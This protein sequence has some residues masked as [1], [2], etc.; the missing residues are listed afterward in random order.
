MEDLLIVLNNLWNYISGVK[1]IFTKKFIEQRYYLHLFISMCINILIIQYM[2]LHVD[3]N[4]IGLFWQMFLSGFIAY[5]YNYARE[6]YL[7]KQGRARF[8][9]YDVFMG[10]YGGILSVIILEYFIL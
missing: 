2:I 7:A 3:L 8:D 1:Y 6:W 9:I 5:I 10:S 4:D